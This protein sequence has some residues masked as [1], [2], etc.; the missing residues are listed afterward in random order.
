MTLLRPA[1][2]NETTVAWRIAI[3]RHRPVCLVLTRQNLPILDPEKYPLREGVPRGAYTLA[4]EREPA[5][6]I[7]IATGSE[8]QLALAA[9][10]KLAE[11]KIAARVV[12]MPSWELFEEQSPEYRAQV[13]PKDVPKLAIEAGAT[14]GWYKYVGEKGAVIGVDR[15]GASAPGKT[16]M[17]KLGINVDNIVQ[18]ARQLVRR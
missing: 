8:V 6:V 15:F 3:E 10:D 12:S 14:L 16:V 17:E 1:D 13:L 18:H 5:D 11:K 9:R 2:A 7:L 4:G